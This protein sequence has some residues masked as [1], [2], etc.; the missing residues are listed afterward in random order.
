MYITMTQREAQYS[1][2]LG[3]E[4]PQPL[5]DVGGH[6]RAALEI[7]VKSAVSG[8]R[9]CFV[10][11]SGGR[12]SSAVLAVATHVARANALPDPV[13]VT[14]VYPGNRSANESEWQELVV[15]HLQLREWVRFPGTA[16][17]DLLGQAVRASLLRRGLLWPPAIHLAA[18]LLDQV[19]GGVLL[20]GEGGDEVLGAH[21]ITPFRVLA[22]DRRWLGRAHAVAIAQ[23][24][25]PAPARRRH[26]ARAFAA[27]GLQPW[28]RPAARNAHFRR[29]A[30]DLASEPLG[31]DASV[32][33]L[34]RR[35]SSTVASANHRALGREHDV[36]V[37]NPLLDDLFL[38]SLAAWGGR[39][40]TSGRTTA[41]RALVGDLLPD[42]ILDRR[43]KALF[44]DAFFGPE[45]QHF[46]RTWDGRG[47]DPAVVDAE[48]L[49]DEWLAPS[50]SAMSTPPLHA[51]WLTHARAAQG[52][53]A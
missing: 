39:W 28:L 36:D 45:T 49:R 5:P 1:W 6:P 37:R 19:R 16:Q 44:N 53:A 34:R 43:S 4:P 38:G 17:S 7:V 47:F 2:V 26:M 8:S 46:A 24:L 35:H 42:Q 40:G 50:P 22:R 15:R 29:V 51:A 25:A 31:W 3:L 13:P 20:T 48:R 33:W 41:L 23:A 18:N 30:E 10:A 32:R 14:E 9:P 27:N 12:D 52:T 21:R 11:F